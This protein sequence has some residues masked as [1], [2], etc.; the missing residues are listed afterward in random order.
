MESALPPTSAATTMLAPEEMFAPPSSSSLVANTELTPEE[1]QK[2]RGKHR[3]AKQALNQRLEGMAE[4]YGK[5]KE[6]KKAEKDKALQGLVRTG[7]GVTVVGKGD[8]E[9]RKKRVREEMGEQDGKRL[10]L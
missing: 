8:K 5:K 3:K 4:L 2:Q 10:K 6:S 1:K 7:K 9:V